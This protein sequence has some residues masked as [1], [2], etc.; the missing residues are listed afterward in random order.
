M[1]SSHERV[2]AVLNH[3]KP[4]RPPLNYFGP[5]ETTQKLLAHLGLESMEQLQ[6]YFGADFR[7]VGPKY[8]GPSEYCGITGFEGGTTD[9]WGIRWVESS[10]PYCTYYEPVPCLA[11]AQTIADLE[12]HPWPQLD[13][14]TFDHLRPQIQA[15]NDKDR[16]AIV[17]SGLKFFEVASWMRGFEQFFL[18][19]IERP[20]FVYYMMEKVT[21]FYRDLT[22]RALD[23]AGDVIDI[24]WSSS[25]VGGQTNL[26]FSPQTWREQVK[27]WHQMLV[28][29]FKEAG[30][31]TRYHTDGAV[32]PIIEDLIDMGLDLLDPIQPNTPGMEP[33]ELVEK[34]GGRL[35]YYGGI[36][37]QTILPYG[38]P[39]E[40][41]REVLRYI[42]VLG[43]QN[44]YGY[45]VAASNAIQPDVPV[46]NILSLFR[47]AQEYRY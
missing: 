30:Y 20:E 37:T 1:M 36:N 15:F 32:A 35:A 44:S 31:K 45:C 2:M 41:E 19:M 29:P 39:T 11:E 42:D 7:Y 34:F 13:W 23:A 17:L 40:V 16:Y 25:D 46:E 22:W 18:D 9:V 38:T 28:T 6:Q 4:D 12:A 47:T 43:R 24:I 33:E 14:F 21:T 5:A 26:L 8:V 27:P 3:E 10:N